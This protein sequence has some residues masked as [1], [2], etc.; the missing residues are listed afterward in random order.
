M[1]SSP[2]NTQEYEVVSQRQEIASRYN[3][4]NHPTLE[5][6]TFVLQRCSEYKPDVRKYF[7]LIKNPTNATSLCF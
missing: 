3:S 4:N 7:S 5:K 1:V 2:P 6:S